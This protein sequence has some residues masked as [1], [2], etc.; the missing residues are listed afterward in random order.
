MKSDYLID[1]LAFVPP[2]TMTNVARVG[3]YI[4]SNM[5]LYKE[6]LI[7]RVYRPNEK[8]ARERIIR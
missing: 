4:F 6:N 7:F 2:S 8:P 5:S 3:Y 1:K